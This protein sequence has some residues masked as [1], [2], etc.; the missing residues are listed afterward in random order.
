M[1]ENVKIE[2]LKARLVALLRREA[3]KEGRFILASGKISSYYLDGRVITLT[4]E[5]AY[6]VASIIL[7]M[8]RDKK[9]DAVG[10]PTL[11]ADPICGSVAALS[12]VNNVKIKTFIV[13]K[14]A[15]EHGTRQMVEGPKL[16][17]G[18]RVI[19]LDDVATTGQSLIEAKQVLDKMGVIA[20]QAIVIV[21]RLEGAQDNLAKAGLNLASIFTVAELL[22]K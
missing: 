5:G 17:S 12:H 14:T 20:E 10:G 8:I 4:P 19:L 2:E 1:I 13:R 7:E 6:L 9:I 18:S 15:K 16:A 21:D 22:S 11:G 3:L